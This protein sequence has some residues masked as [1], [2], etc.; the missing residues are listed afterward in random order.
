MLTY[1]HLQNIP[2]DFNTTNDTFILYQMFLQNYTKIYT[3]EAELN[4]NYLTF[5][6]NYYKLLDI[7]HDIQDD[8][9]LDENDKLKLDITT[10][11]DLTDEDY[12]KIYLNYNV[13]DTEINESQTPSNDTFFGNETDI[14]RHL[15]TL[16]RNFDWRSRGV[17][18]RVKNQGI[19]GSCYAFSATGNIESLYALKYGT[20]LDLSEQQIL[21]CD[22]NQNG[23]TG[24]SVANALDYIK[25]VGGLG[26]ESSMRYVGRRQSCYA[27]RPYAKVVG[28][29]YAGTQNEDYI[30]SFLVKNGPLST[31][32]NAKYFKYYRGGIM[33]F[34]NYYCSPY[35]LDHAVL[36][37]GYGVTGTGIKYWIVKNSWGSNWGENGFLRIGRGVCGINRYVLSGV[38]A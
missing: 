27:I 8:N 32:V 17:V 33:R 19:C 37:V 35:K 7:Q 13:T 11:F 30:K 18:T 14:G 36:I 20:L 29:K 10:L 9:D 6:E 31:G 2:I 28:K 3:T 23:C 1:V 26:S 15:Q 5:L 21:S 25:R 12:N 38:I 22:R 34:S 16:P 24:G 4:M